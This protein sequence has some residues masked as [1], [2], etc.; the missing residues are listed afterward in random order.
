VIPGP[1]PDAPRGRTR[2]EIIARG[3]GLAVWRMVA[4]RRDVP[5]DIEIPPADFDANRPALPEEALAI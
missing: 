5:K 4:R 1:W 3:K 2:R